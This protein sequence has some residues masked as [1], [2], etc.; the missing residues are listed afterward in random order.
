MLIFQLAIILKL[1][2]MKEAAFTKKNALKWKAMEDGHPATPDE[3]ASQF[4]VLTDDLSY[5]RTFYPGS[6]TE[7]YL[8]QLTSQK[9]LRIYRNK[10]LNRNRFSHFWGREIPLLIASHRQQ[11]LLGLLFFCI[12]IFIGLVSASRDETYVRLILGDAYVNRTL[13]NIG[14]GDPMAIYKSYDAGSSFLYI[15]FNNIRVSFFAFVAGILLSAGSILLLISNGIM[16]GAF[17]YFFYQK[18]LLITSVLS[19]WIHGTLEITSIVIAGGAGIVLGNSILFPGSYPRMHAFRRGAEHGIKL[20]IALVPFFIF[21]GFL[22]GFVT[23]HTFMPWYWSISIIL[24]SLASVFFYFL[25][26]PYSHSKK[27]INQ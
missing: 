20:V 12:G 5:A 24:I 3:V 9:F 6:K 1:S 25:W 11:L 22:E 26:L 7:A 15:T 8:N 27:M 23:R 10:R 18:G 17:Q 13:E 14:K 2:L 19:I 21:A 4:I 16:L